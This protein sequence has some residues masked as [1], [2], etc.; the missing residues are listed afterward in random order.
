MRTLKMCESC[1]SHFARLGGNTIFRL[2]L[3]FPF[4]VV[5]FVVIL[6]HL[7]DVMN[8]FLDGSRD[9]GW[10]LGFGFGRFGLVWSGLV[11]AVSWV[12]SGGGLA[13]LRK[14]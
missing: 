10:R 5:R 12:L 3:D 7:Y 4:Q 2:S 8:S 13:G 6:F 11:W 14:C 9:K 1:G